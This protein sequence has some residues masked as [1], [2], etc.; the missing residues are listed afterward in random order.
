MRPE[1]SWCCKIM[2]SLRGAIVDVLFSVVESEEG[3]SLGIGNFLWST[4]EEE[5][6]KFLCAECFCDGN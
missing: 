6:S 5:V 4:Q 2:S 1:V 3:M